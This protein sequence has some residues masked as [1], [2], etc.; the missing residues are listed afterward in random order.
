[1]YFWLDEPGEEGERYSLR[2]S[3]HHAPGGGGWNDERQERHA[4]PDINIVI[5]RG[6]GGDYTFDLGPIVEILGQ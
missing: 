5:C 4:A 1:M 3:D 2:I 6:E